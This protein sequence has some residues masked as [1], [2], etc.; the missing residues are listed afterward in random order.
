MFAGAGRHWPRPE[1]SARTRLACA[2]QA[3]GGMLE[4]GWIQHIATSLCLPDRQRHT[5]WTCQTGPR[6]PPFPMLDTRHAFDPTDSIAAAKASLLKSLDMTHLWQA[7][8][9]LVTKML[10][11]HSCSL[12]FDIDGYHPQQ[13]RHHL[14]ETRDNGARLV[15]SLE[16]AAPYLDANPQVAWYTLSQIASQDASAMTRLRAQDPAPIWREFIHLAFWSGTRLDAVLSIRINTEHTRLSDTE[17]SFLAELYPLLDASIKR[18]HSVEAAQAR[19]LAFESLVYKLPIAMAIVDQNLIPTYISR[20]AER[21]CHQWHDGSETAG[22]LPRLIETRLRRHIQDMPR[23]VDPDEVPR[24]GHVT[25]T[26]GHP[27]HSNLHLGLEIGSPMRTSPRHAH[28][29]LTFIPEDGAKP[30]DR[31]ARVQPLLECLSPSERRVAMLVAEGLRNDAIARKLFRSP[32]TIESQISSVYRKLGI[33]N[34]T[35]LARLLS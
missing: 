32:K 25:L 31:L 13:G 27:R 29:L 30:D 6:K 21:I 3:E 26:I 11:C 15:T 12:M 34:R 28:R 14:A 4:I 20:E 2:C 33:E 10:P 8:A 5:T 17:L 16:V 24:E 9:L 23:D 1:A 19:H 18:V 7:C 22:H 35:Q